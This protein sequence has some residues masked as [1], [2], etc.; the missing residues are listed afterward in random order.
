MK[1]LLILFSAA[2]FIISCGNDNNSKTD[3]GGTTGTDASNNAAGGTETTTP[4]ATAANADADRGLDLIAQSDCLTCHKVEEKLVG[5]AYREVA[6][7]YPNNQATI[8]TLASR[9]IKGGAG[10]WGQ[11]P[12]T[13][14]P[15]LSKEDAQTMVKYVMSLKQ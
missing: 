5:P 2:S 11:V 6:A 10:N 8:D 12:M 7:K 13:P 3:A 4:A 14:H 9:I 1:K 15:Q